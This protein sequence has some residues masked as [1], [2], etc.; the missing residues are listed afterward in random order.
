M[1]TKTQQ[2]Y[3]LIIEIA[4]ADA[5]TT[6][7]TAKFE[8]LLG[9]DYQIAFDMWEYTLSKY[10]TDLA[11]P[12][13]CMIYEQNLFKMFSLAG[14]TKFRTCL[15]ES[16]PMLKL[17]YGQCTSAGTGHNLAFIVNLVLSN[18]I[19]DADEILRAMKNNANIDFNE[20]LKDVVDKVFLEYCAR[21]DVRVPV[22]N[23]KQKTLLM[24]YISK[25][26][27]PNKALLTQ[28]IKE[29]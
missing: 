21:N 11:D 13:F 3:N 1:N 23:K 24:D 27:N 6:N 29:L 9:N 28:R 15:C 7:L 10:Q 19:E 25:I 18:K 4:G 8:E 20:R 14:D 17:V 2:K 12:K 5:N 22:L 26:K 16:L